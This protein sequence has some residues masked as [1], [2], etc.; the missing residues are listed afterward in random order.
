MSPP[1]SPSNK[2]T[3][4]LAMFDFDQTIAV[5]NVFTA[6]TEYPRTQVKVSPPYATNER[7]Q[8]HR[9]QQLDEEGG[10]HY[11]SQTGKLVKDSVEGDR[12]EKFSWSIASLGGAARVETLRSFFRTLSEDKH[13]TLAIITRGNIGCVQL[14][15]HN[16][17]LLKYFTGGVFGNIGDRYGATEFDLSFNNSVSLSSL[18]GDEDHA[19]WSRKTDVIRRLMGDKYEPNEAVFVEDDIKELIAAAKLCRG[20]YVSERRGM[21]DDNFQEILSLCK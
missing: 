1:Y 7:G 13:V 4:K 14:V 9:I 10:W 18:E 20:V 17:G 8:M 19:S 15:L 12:H 3:L 2:S 6:L 5:F 11:D 21:T 16:C